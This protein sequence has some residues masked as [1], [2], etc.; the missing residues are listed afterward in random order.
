MVARQTLSQLERPL[1]TAAVDFRFALSAA[2]RSPKTV[3]WYADILAGFRAFA[4]AE[5]G[6]EPLVGDLSLDLARRYSARLG[7][8]GP[9][10]NG[11]GRA[12]SSATR[13]G[14]LVA[15]KAFAGWLR[16]ER[17]LARDPLAGLVVP[18]AEE[19]LFPVFS[20]QQLGALLAETGGDSLRDR[21]WAAVVWLLL[22]GGLR[23]SELT[24]LTA[25]RLDLERGEARVLGKGGRE[26]LVPIGAAAV[27]PLRRYLTQRGE[28]MGDEPVFLDQAGRPLTRTAVYRGVR[29]LGRR[30]GISG[31]RCSPHTFRHSFATR[32]LT[33]GGDVLT[34][35]RL[36]GHS[37]RSLAVT[38]RYV[39]LLDEDLR[40]AHRRASP[41]DH[42]A[43]RLGAVRA[44]RSS[45][46]RR[47]AGRV[48]RQRRAG[49]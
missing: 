16:R 45:G 47:P 13:H 1:A 30:A 39:T 22:D 26:R 32:F 48:A 2:G 31:V 46:W 3:A 25:E 42:L 19:R 34:L 23:L 9:R 36:L 12:V 49:V 6:H 11:S 41:G 33:L 37:P 27:S 21:R 15:L 17:Y 38:Q 20:D 14:Y 18:R 7:G 5:L 44:A 28:P 35:Q 29:N 40:V 4:L 8:G 43:R 10:A 24:S